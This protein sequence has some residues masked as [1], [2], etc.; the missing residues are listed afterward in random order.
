MKKI[1]SGMI[2]IITVILTVLLAIEILHLNILPTKYLILLLIG[3]IVTLGL[4]FFLL[5]RKKQVSKIIGLILLIIILGCNVFGLYHIH[6]INAFI[7]NSFKVVKT[8]KIKYYVIAKKENNYKKKDISGEIGYYEESIN[9]SEAIKSLKKNYS[10]EEENFN[11]LNNLFDQLDQQ[12]LKFVLIEK[13]NFNIIMELDE[14]RKE[15]DY[16]VLYEF[17]INKKLKSTKSNREDSFNIYV[18]GTDYVGLMDFNTIITV[19]TKTHTILLT[20]IPRDYYVDV[21]GYG[22]KNKLSFITE[23]IDVSK[24]SIANL[25]GIN[26]DYFIKIDSDSVVK[27]IDEIGGIEYCSDYAYNGAYNVYSNGYRKSISYSIKKGCQHLDGYEAIAASRTRNAF[28]GRDRVRQQNMQKIMVAILKKLATK[29]TIVNYE[30]ILN[31]LSNSYETDIPK[32]IMTSS[33]KDIINNGNRWTIE[34]QSVDGDDGHD[35]V[36][37]F[38]NL[39]DWVMYPNMDTVH[40]ATEKINR[41][42]EAKNS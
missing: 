5:T 11:D 37:R 36:H 38:G 26:I 32:K 14:N 9:I 41:N 19:N 15:E 27:L 13:T 29:E 10:V 33:V 2:S 21:V 8:E 18:G 34:V 39:T 20:S 40:S 28:N 35:T 23:G 25:F 42:L 7:D 1:L 3:I 4:S 24:E 31:D 16:Q 17:S 6:N 22:Y 30:E 12:E